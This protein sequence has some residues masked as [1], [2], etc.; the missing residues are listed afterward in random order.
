MTKLVNPA[1]ALKR[2]GFLVPNIQVVA[3]AAFL[4]TA[5]AALAQNATPTPQSSEPATDQKAEAEKVVTSIDVKPGDNW[6]YQVYNGIT[7][8]LKWTAHYTVTE[9]NGNTFS[10]AYGTETPNGT[11]GGGGDALNVFDNTWNILEDSNWKWSVPDPRSGI[12]L[13]LKVGAEWSVKYVASNKNSNVLLTAT[14]TLRVVSKGS[15]TL[16]SGAAYDAYKIET[17]E[18]ATFSSTANKYEFKYTEWYAPT[19]NRY[20]K[21]TNETRIDGRL[22]SIYEENFTS[23]TRR[24]E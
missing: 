5:G 9:I 8:E 22:T 12:V 1:R 20:V 18:R 24:S 17:V 23:Y 11:I 7:G 3:S 4:F 16:R 2:R 14:A 6:V 19:V 10:V 21:W 13:P 15:V